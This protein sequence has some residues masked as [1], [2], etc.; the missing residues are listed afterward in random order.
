M[1]VDERLLLVL[2]EREIFDY[3]CT[4]WSVTV[5]RIRF[6]FGAIDR[7]KRKRDCRVSRPYVNRCVNHRGC[8][9]TSLQEAREWRERYASTRANQRWITQQTD[10]QRDNNSQEDCTL[11]PLA[12][13][14]DIAFRGYDAILDLVE[15]LPKSVAAQCNPADP[16]LALSV[17]EAACTRLHCKAYDMYAVWS[18]GGLHTS[19]ATDAE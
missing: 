9:T 11:I 7:G 6:A 2:P 10:E 13:A 8:P 19:T 16:Q 14:T 5:D 12:T 3:L 1:P 17:L 4:G 15:R 18:K